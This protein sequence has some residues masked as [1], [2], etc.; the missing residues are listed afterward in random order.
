[1]TLFLYGRPRH[2]LWAFV[3]F[4]EHK[5]PRLSKSSEELLEAFGARC[6][7]DPEEI[8]ETFRA[9]ELE[10]DSGECQMELCRAEFRARRRVL[11]SPLTPYKKIGSSVEHGVEEEQPGRESPGEPREESSEKPI[12]VSQEENPARVS[13]RR[14]KP[15]GASRR[16]DRNPGSTSPG[17]FPEALEAPKARRVEPI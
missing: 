17:L 13:Q 15:L 8:L 11:N 4:C 5:D 1:M 7:L 9:E 12:R 16:R 14:E 10:H 6:G 3:S 2:L